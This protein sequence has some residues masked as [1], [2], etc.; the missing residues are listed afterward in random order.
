MCEVDCVPT[1]LD[2][3]ANTATC[4]KKVVTKKCCDALSRNRNCPDWTASC[5]AAEKKK[6]TDE[7]NTC[8]N[9]E[10]PAKCMATN[11]DVDATNKCEIDAVPVQ[12]C[13]QVKALNAATCKAADFSKLSYCSTEVQSKFTSASTKC[14]KCTASLSVSV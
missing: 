10:D 6:I 8:K 2:V 5:S 9:C 11:L 3:A 4:S 12:C 7:P 1:A 14:K 13:T